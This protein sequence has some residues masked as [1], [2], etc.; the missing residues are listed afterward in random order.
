MF[1]LI[2]AI[3]KYSF[4]VLAI[5]VLSHVIEIQGVTVSQ[6]VLNGMH[7]LSGYNPK[8]KATQITTDYSKIMEAH[9]KELNSIDTGGAEAS[10][11]DQKALNK[12]I[13]NSQFKKK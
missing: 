11:E 1:K 13:E 6:H 10:L 9:I 7:M 2:G 8:T 12:V 4:L 3:F 5:L